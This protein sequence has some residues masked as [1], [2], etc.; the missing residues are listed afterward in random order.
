MRLAKKVLLI[1]WDAADWKAITPLLDAGKMP[2]LERLV[3]SGVMGNLATLQ[4]PLSPMVWTSIA[5]G[6]RPF[7]H[8]VLGFTE[9]DPTTGGVRPISTLSRKVKA[10]WNILNQNGHRSNVIGWW[11]S[12]PA[13]PINGVMV[14]N[15]YQRVLG[16]V[17]KPWPMQ[18]GTVHP[19][20]LVGPLGGLR[21]HPGELTAA[22]ILPFVPKAAEIDQEKDRRLDGLARI[23]A[24]CSTIHACATAVIQLEPWDFMAVYYDAIDHFGHGFMRY[25]P[26]R[27]E[28]VSERDFELYQGVIEAGYR[29]HDMMLGAMLKLAGPETTVILVSDHGFHP[30]HLRPA[31]IP[32]EPA[33]PAVEHSPYGVL[34]M[35]GPGI[36]QDERVYGASLL[37]VTPTVLTLFG[38]PVGRDMLGKPLVQ[39]L[40][41]PPAVESIASWE[42]V[43]GEAGMHPPERRFDP[44]EAQEGIKQLVAL[45]Y[46]E[47]PGDDPQQ[48]VAKT[49][50]ETRYDLARSYMDADRYHDAVPLLEELWRQWPEELRFANYLVHCYTAMGCLPELRRSVEKLLTARDH[51]TVKAQEKLSEAADNLRAKEKGSSKEA[52]GGEDAQQTELG[53]QERWELMR[54]RSLAHPHPLEADYLR[55]CLLF[56][57]GRHDEALGHLRLVA[58]AEPR[59]PDMHLHL[60]SVFAA[61][62]RW[63]DAEEAFATALDIDPNSAPAHFGLARCLL[64]QGQNL[65]AAERALAA[66]G[67]LY[68]FPQAHFCLG[69]ALHRTGR[70]GPAV[71]AFRVALS[72]HPGMV[73]AH[74][75]LAF[76]YHHRLGDLEKAAHHREQACEIRHLRR[77][78]TGQEPMAEAEPVAAAEAPAVAPPPAPVY[79]PSAV[80]PDG[81]EPEWLDAGN[82]PDTPE[83]R[84]T[85]VSG[86]PRS[87]TSMMMQMLAAGGLAVLAD[88][89][90]AADDDNPR[91]YFEF[92]K[93]KRLRMDRSWLPAARGKAV[94]IVAHLLPLLPPRLRYRIIFMERDLDEVIASQHTMLDRKGRAGAA[95]SDRKL[96]ETFARQVRE[97]KSVLLARKLPSLFVSHAEALRCPQEV[98]ARVNG[99]LGGGLDHSA[100][101]AAVDRSL[102]RHVRG[103]PSA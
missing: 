43:P 72:Q 6:M 84:I 95:L 29:Y 86:L 16:P 93:A 58:Q 14:S 23:I 8:G 1:G 88:E 45:G 62:K 3:N 9:V 54:W 15:H 30:D 64:A 75:R 5:T 2:A 66:V 47:D 99:F 21:I 20:R 12:H 31:A 53:D 56:A 35:K 87:G 70:V 33:G 26:P 50:R 78:N 11:P 59:N 82:V 55:G 103:G 77:L 83:E 57:E 46:I 34:V 97:V 85:I 51:L 22:H 74:D 49:V 19:E 7:Q 27:Q 101:A 18:P 94:K 37:D 40:T 89:T 90:R 69:V 71:D 80:A 91:G 10:I 32:F 13:E 67:L 24:D 42:L 36:K 76:I 39:A 65:A 48:A 4:P 17:D 79:P 38:L 52:A 100:M 98:A 73:E 41:E 63:D 92:D 25:H 102:H 61:M 28:H 81:P 44:V 96:A 60:G 68:Y